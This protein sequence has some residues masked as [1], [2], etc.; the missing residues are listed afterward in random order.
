MLCAVVFVRMYNVS[1]DGKFVR[2]HR[3]GARH[4]VRG[5]LANG[6]HR[7]LPRRVVTVSAHYFRQC[8]TRPMI[9][10][11]VDILCVIEL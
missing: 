6:T 2:L 4:N 9:H 10:G 11:N 7:V 5:D 1:S 8:H 3:F